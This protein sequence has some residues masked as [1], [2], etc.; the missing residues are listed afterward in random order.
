MLLSSCSYDPGHV[1]SVA[2]KW[3]LWTLAL[4]E[5]VLKNYLSIGVDTFKDI[6]YV[7]KIA[8]RPKYK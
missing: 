4:F 7:V 6:T 2:L 5:H 3:T 1:V 8:S